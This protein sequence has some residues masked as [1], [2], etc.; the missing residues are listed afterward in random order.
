MAA[1]QTTTRTRVTTRVRTRTR[2][3]PTIRRPSNA[4]GG[5]KRCPTCG[6]FM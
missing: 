3:T 6:K 1:R 2:R 4:A 5:K